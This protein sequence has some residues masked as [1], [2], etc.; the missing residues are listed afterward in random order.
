MGLQVVGVDLSSL[1][2]DVARQIARASEVDMD[3]RVMDAMDLQFADASFDVALFSYNGLELLPG[4]EGKRQAMREVF[5]ILKP[6]GHF[7]FSSHSLFALNQFTYL[8]LVT[9]VKFAL[10]WLLGLPFKE[11]ELGERFSED[12]D[13]E[14]RYLQIL[15]PSTL[16]R[17]LGECGFEVVE[18][19]TRRRLEQGKKWS[20]RGVFD[21]GERLYV[22]RK[23]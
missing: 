21:D 6:G 10:G 12:E 5:R 11:R 20:V 8:R 1:M 17:M 16:L 9:F 3:F 23:N 7:I 13:E 19:N 14:V 22:A 4:L 2:I 18:F 15:P